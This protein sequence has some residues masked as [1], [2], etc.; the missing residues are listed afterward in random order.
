MR[1]TSRP[2]PEGAQ[3]IGSWGYVFEALCYLSTVTNLTVV[4]FTNT[5]PIF[6]KD[7]E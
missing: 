3:S 7:C 6:G 4:V 2:M 5:G 1:L